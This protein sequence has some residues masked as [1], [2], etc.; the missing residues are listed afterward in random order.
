MCSVSILT[1]VLY[2]LSWTPCSFAGRMCSVSDLPSF[3]AD[4]VSCY[5]STGCKSFFPNV[6]YIGCQ[7]L[8][9]VLLYYRLHVLCFDAHYLLH[10]RDPELCASQR[11]GASSDQSSCTIQHR[12]NARILEPTMQEGPPLSDP[13][14][15]SAPPSCF[16]LT[17]SLLPQNRFALLGFITLYFA[18][19]G[20]YTEPHIARES[21]GSPQ[22]VPIKSREPPRSLPGVPKEYIWTSPNPSRSQ[23]L[24]KDSPRTPYIILIKRGLLRESHYSPTGTPSLY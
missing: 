16:W 4:R 1:F 20:R 5:L 17:Q 9:D 7:F 2:R 3:D 23:G 8:S 13:S 24:P 10:T 21:P 12:Y 15:E 6:F 11:S 14:C 22:G 18:H 19:R